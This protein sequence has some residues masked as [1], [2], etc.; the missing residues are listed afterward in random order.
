MLYHPANYGGSPEALAAARARYPRP[1]GMDTGPGV[2]ILTR[3]VYEVRDVEDPSTAE[4]IRAVG[5][6]LG[7]RSVITVPMLRENEAIGAIAVTRREPGPFSEGDMALL[8]TF[9]DQAVIAIENARL[10]KELEARNRDLTEALDQQT[11]TSEILRVISSSPTSVEAVFDTI[12]AS[13]LRLCDTPT[14][15]IFTFDGRAFHIAA[16]AH[17]S[18]EFLAAL[19]E[20]VILPGPETPLR[21]VGLNLEMSHV[22]DIFSDPSFSPPEAYRLEGMR[23]SLAVPMLKEGRLVGALTF[24]RREVRPFTEAQV[25][26]IKIFADQAVIAIENVRL[27]KELEARNRDLTEALEQQT[28]TAE[29]LRVIS[30]SPTNLQ[31]VLDTVVASAARFCGAYDVILFQVEG[32]NLRFPAHYGPIPG[33]AGSSIPLVRGSVAGRTVLERRVV[34]LADVQ[35]ETE[36]FPDTAARAKAE[37]H[38]TTVGVPLLREGAAIGAL[39][40]RRTEVDPFVDKQIAL[41]QTFADQAVIAI[42][43]VRLFKEL[44]ARNRD[45][46]NALEQQTATSDVLRII[47]QSPTELQPV[48]DAIATSAVR[49]C[50]AS[51]VVIERLEGDRFYNAAHA[52]SQMKGLVGHPLPLTRRFPGGR[53][54]LDRRP[55]IIDDIMLIAES[56]YPDTLELLKLNTVHSCAEIPL[57]SEGKSLGNLAVLRAE[58]R[59]FTDAEVA[60]LQTFADQAVIAIENVR[61]F[62]ELQARTHELTQ[63]VEQLTA[64]GELSRAVSSTLDVETVLRTVVSRARDLAG[65]DGCLIYEYDATTEQ[66]H[67]RA[68]DNLEGDFG[69]AMRRMPIRKGE[70]VS[71]RAAEMR[72]PFQVADITQ[73]GIYDS[74]V[75]EVVIR[76]GYRAA[77]SVPLLREDE[78]IGSLILIRKTPGEFSAEIIEALKTFATQSALAIQNARLFHEIEDKGRQLEVASRHKSQFLAN[79]SHELRTP[80]NA[81]LGYTELLLDGIYGALPEKAGETMARIDRSGRHLLALINDVLDLSKIEAGQLTLSLADYSLTEVIHTVVTAVEPL[82]AEK[83]LGLR[84]ALEPD[85]PLAR[86]DDR[87]ISQVLLNLVG[88][89]VKF[90]DAGEVRIEAKASDGS[91]LISVSDTGP[92]IATEDQGRIFEEFQQ[93]DTSNTR[94]KGGTG[95][96]LSI[97]K[98]ILALH[99]GRIWVASTPGMGS[100]FS[101]TLPVRVERM[102]EAS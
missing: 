90:T 81:I 25:A 71:G 77:L 59:P 16:A 18:D 98:R 88:N 39:V 65:A 23:T 28:A 41:L 76:A 42:E 84:V 2:A 30:T 73:P 55:I 82:A 57:L 50:V 53:A 70:G 97:A 9:A 29:I 20:A 80:L 66:F 24:H 67:V 93:A 58:V 26:L 7:F 14:G 95:L 92:G 48:L 47:A 68:T 3:S 83:G 62:E 35:A 54:V 43:N 100:T 91:F 31:P 19:R 38:R 85:L 51:D 86:G 22:A 99:G 37:G 89:A 94:K 4:H 27:F 46:T 72:E 1:L 75:R 74:S 13:A 21:R 69:E 79:M 78:V 5:R 49:L 61:L 11:A 32:D 87:R 40:L 10:F 45:L 15:G 96:G 36:E 56:E 6:V 63:S 64:L 12:L 44:E 101:F 33:P 17:W 52:G 34:H 60:L 102:A 8:Q